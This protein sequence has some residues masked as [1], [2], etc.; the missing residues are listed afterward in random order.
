L[1]LELLFLFVFLFLGFCLFAFIAGFL[2]ASYPAADSAIHAAFF[3]RLPAQ[4]GFIFVT[5]CFAL[6]W[7]PHIV[8]GRRLKSQPESERPHDREGPIRKGGILAL[9]FGLG[10]AVGG[11]IGGWMSGNPFAWLGG[12]IGGFAGGFYAGRKLARSKANQDNPK[13][14]LGH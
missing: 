2:E 7:L 1:T 11:A 4:M 14:D 5:T 8:S 3:D 9:V 6:W 13:I 12:A 10:G